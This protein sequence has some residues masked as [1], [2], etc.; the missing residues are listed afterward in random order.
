MSCLGIL[1]PISSI[2]QFIVFVRMWQSSCNF[3]TRNRSIIIYLIKTKKT[4]E[5]KNY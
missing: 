5:Y 3:A 2:I 4:Y 1:F